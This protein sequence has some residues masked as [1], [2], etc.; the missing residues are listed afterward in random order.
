MKKLFLFSTVILYI[1]VNG[2]QKNS[3]KADPISMIAGG[4]TNLISYERAISNHSTV[5]IG[6]GYATFK[7]DSYKYNYLGANVFY[8]YYFKEAL[9][10]FYLTGSTG[11]GG[12]RTKYTADTRNLRDN[13]TLIDITARVGYQ[14]VW[15]SGLTLD[16]NAGGHYARIDYKSDNFANNPVKAKDSEIFPNI[17]IGLGYS[18]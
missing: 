17:G 15:K 14:W 13:Y 4:G 18:F 8:R 7:V 16:L 3:V 9:R 12:G 1:T 11:C 6:T 2:Q 10:G 5:G